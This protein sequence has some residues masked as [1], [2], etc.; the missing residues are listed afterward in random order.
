M[1]NYTRYTGGAADILQNRLCDKF[2][3]MNIN[4]GYPAY[5]TAVLKTRRS[6]VWPAKL[7]YITDQELKSGFD[8]T[9][10]AMIL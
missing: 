6:K 9:I 7:I 8:A 2:K 3:R 5:W 10:L 1:L 4:N